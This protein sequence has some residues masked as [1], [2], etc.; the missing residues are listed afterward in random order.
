MCATPRIGDFFDIYTPLFK[1]FLQSEY[2]NL[3]FWDSNETHIVQAQEKLV[4]EF[5]EYSE[6]GENNSVLDVGFG[7]GEQD[8]YFLNH[9][10]CKRI[11]GINISPNQVNMANEKGAHAI[12]LKKR[13][14]F[15]L[16]NALDLKYEKKEAFDRVLALECSHQ[17]LDKSLFIEGAYHVLSNGG[18]LSLAEPI[19]NDEKAYSTHMIGDFQEELKKLGFDKNTVLGGGSKIRQL[20]EGELSI[21]EQHPSFGLFLPQLL[22]LFEESP[23]NSYEIRDITSNLIPFYSNYKKAILRYLQSNPQDEEQLIFLLGIFFIR[24]VCFSNKSSGFYM[25]KVKK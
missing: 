10:K 4:K 3:G 19:H 5:G 17:F 22:K 11:L 9:F 12:Q 7:T 1:N 16:G 2:L 14:R 21:K 8:L 23:F 13:L 20:I 24:H 6:L 25:I 15:K 18:L